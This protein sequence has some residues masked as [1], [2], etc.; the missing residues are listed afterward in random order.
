MPYP[1]FNDA[2]GQGS[3]TPEPPPL[4]AKMDTQP[5]A[6]PWNTFDK[7]PQAPGGNVPPEVAMSEYR[8][9]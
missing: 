1:T 7:P 8:G 6:S 9:K 2:Y 4:E 5:L 3:N